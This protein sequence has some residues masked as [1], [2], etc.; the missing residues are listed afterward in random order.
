MNDSD[1]YVESLAA[2]ALGSIGDNRARSALLNALK[3]DTLELSAAAS[4]A[5]SALSK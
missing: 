5:L 1:L 2:E 4:K 3:D